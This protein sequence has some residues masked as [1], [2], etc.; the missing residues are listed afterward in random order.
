MVRG[1]TRRVGNSLRS[2]QEPLLETTLGFWWQVRWYNSQQVITLSFFPFQCDLDRLQMLESYSWSFPY[3]EKKPPYSFH[4]RR[5]WRA[6]FKSLYGNFFY[7]FKWIRIRKTCSL[8]GL[9]LLLEFEFNWLGRLLTILWPEMKGRRIRSVLAW[10][11]ES[12]EPLSKTH[13]PSC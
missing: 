11:P 1:V 10:C 3:N 12:P 9:S 7:L 5:C 2:S 8:L 4:P 13:E 6:I